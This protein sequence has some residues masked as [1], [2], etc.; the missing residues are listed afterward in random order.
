MSV[1][2][3][4]GSYALGIVPV[5][6]DLLADFWGDNIWA[7]MR[8]RLTDQETATF[9]EVTRRWPDTIALVTTFQRIPERRH[10]Q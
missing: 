8:K 4:V 3:D 5:I 9:T 7:E 6:G 2:R 10:G 1:A